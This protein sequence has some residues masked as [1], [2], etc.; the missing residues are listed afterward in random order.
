MPSVG[1]AQFQ[2]IFFKC[3]RMRFYLY[4]QNNLF[5]SDVQGFTDSFIDKPEILMCNLCNQLN[6]RRTTCC[7]AYRK[8]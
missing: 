6:A 7:T 1:I 5:S 4:Y 3:L 8:M 2:Q